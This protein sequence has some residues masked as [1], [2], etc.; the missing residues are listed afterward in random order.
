M[1][2]GAIVA[3]VLSELGC[4]II[5]GIP[6]DH[7]M[8]IYDRLFQRKDIKHLLV[9][10]E[11]NAA[12]MADV[13]GRLTGEPGICLTTAGPGAT[14]CVTALAQAYSAASPM[15]H[16]SATV[17]SKSPWESFHGVDDENF[18]CNVFRSVT[19][20]SS[21]AERVNDIQLK[22]VEAYNATTTGRMGPVH[23]SIPTNIL[24]AKIEH[25]LPPVVKP[26]RWKAAGEI[27]NDVIRRLMTA[28]RL[29]VYAGKNV[30]RYG[31]E[32]ELLELCELLNAPIVVHRYASNSVP[33]DFK[34]YATYV[35][36]DRAHPAGR[37]TIDSADL[38]LSI[39]VRLGSTEAEPLKKH[40]QNG[41][42]L[43]DVEEDVSCANYA[44]DTVI[45]GNI[46]ETIK[47]LLSKL[48][49]LPRRELDVRL[50]KEISK[51]K[52]EVNEAMERDVK[53]NIDRKP[54]HPSVVVRTFQTMLERD[55]I[56]TKDI[57]NSN[58]SVRDTEG[59]I[60]TGVYGSMGFAL[61]AAIS[62][63]LVYPER[64][65]LAA[66]GDGALLMSYADLPTIIENNLNLII[67]VFN[68]SKYSA[69]Y[70]IQRR[71][72]E[73][74][75]IAT[76]IQPT[77]FA[78]IFRACGGKGVRVEEPRELKTTLEEALSSKS[79]TLIDVIT[80]FSIDSMGSP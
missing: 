65:V 30:S 56:V 6:G 52:E 21:R 74:R 57:G 14:N 36:V 76:D 15:I 60:E 66:T 70:H 31:C 13:Y 23:I 50:L 43:L 4:K 75:F 22:I 40:R 5:F 49:S 54:I 67:L 37:Y 48:K 7:N 59:L 17:P 58:F 20:W 64:Q 71:K 26:Q 61:P 11:A 42:I 32:D 16:L 45:V 3:D 44:V 39:G 19:K 79:A 24:S 78:A 72:F 8:E 34:L 53:A 51:I 69:I 77:D 9:K 10:H 73:S 41:S 80:D 62:A 18:L 25:P 55:A 63:K 33:N 27:S 68:D 35:D 12:I 28:K 29:V 1:K 38:I 2:G 46:K 47:L